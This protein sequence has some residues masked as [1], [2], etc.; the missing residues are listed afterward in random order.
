MVERPWALCLVGLFFGTHAKDNERHAR[1]SA[2]KPGG[3]TEMT[4]YLLLILTL[5]VL[6]LGALPSWKHSRNWGYGP[7]AAL[8]LLAVVFGALLLLGRL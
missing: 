3:E 8:G 4:I 2:K 7:S 1:S 5:V 6:I